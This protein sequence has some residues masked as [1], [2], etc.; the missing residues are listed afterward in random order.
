MD[1]GLAANATAAATARQALVASSLAETRNNADIA[2][3][4]TALAAAEQT[5]ATA[6]ATAFQTLQASADKLSADQI[7]ALVA[8][9]GRGGGAAG[10]G[11][12]AAGGG[13]R[14]GGAPALPE[15]QMALV[16]AFNTDLTAEVTA[17]NT[18]TANLLAASYASP[19]DDAKI[20]AASDALNTARQAWATKASA[21]FAKAQASPTKFSDAAIA[22][23]TAAAPGAAAGGR[24]GGG[25]RGG[26]AAAP[27]GAPRA[28]AGA[29]AGQ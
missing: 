12:A 20:K 25:G 14:G 24:G 27:G 3:K 2:S 7:T 16:T 1:Q 8:Q 18:A 9:A 23:L 13:G 17:V 11:G 22:Q 21:A 6:R 26:A 4:V 19:K 15:D 5:L 29:P 28:G 10:G